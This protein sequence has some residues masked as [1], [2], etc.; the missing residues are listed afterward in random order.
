M[1]FTAEAEKHYNALDTNMGRRVN[2]AIEQLAQNPFFGAN[3]IQLKGALEGDYRYR[4]GGYR[5]V[6]RVNEEQHVIIVRGIFKRE[7]AYR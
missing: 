1:F 7:R 2:V 5:I 6:Y 4:V 3:I